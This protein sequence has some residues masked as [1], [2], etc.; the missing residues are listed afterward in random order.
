MK[1]VKAIIQPFMSNHVLD[2]LHR[3]EGISGVMASEVRCTNAT[4][5]NLNPDVNTRI[6]L[7]V[8]DALVDEVVETIQLHAHT[9]RK[10]DGRIFVI[11]VA[12]AIV[13]RSGE[14]EE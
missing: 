8:P 10:G 2:A 3:I 12:H 13:I 14:K 1:E 4:R 11:D 9:G 6:E 7:I 5:G